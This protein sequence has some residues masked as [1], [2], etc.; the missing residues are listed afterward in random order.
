MLKKSSSPATEWDRQLKFL[1]FTYR[2]TPHA[3]TGFLPA[4]LLYGRHVK[5]PLDL[6]KSSWISEEVK[7]ALLS[8]WLMDAQCIAR[9]MREV[10]ASK[11]EIAKSKM[12]STHDKTAKTRVFNVG[13]Q[14][15]VRRP[16]VHGKLDCT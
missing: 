16:E 7:P 4:D 2:T 11:E 5:G 9:E 14:V 1:L 13:E 12:K 6:I 15:I 10:D 3:V 8:S